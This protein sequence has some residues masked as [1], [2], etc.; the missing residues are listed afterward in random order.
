MLMLAFFDEIDVTQTHE[1][2]SG[3]LGELLFLFSAFSS[4]GDV[5]K[6][7]LASSWSPH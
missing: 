2:K 6:A 1:N 4:S 3:V 7:I 5:G